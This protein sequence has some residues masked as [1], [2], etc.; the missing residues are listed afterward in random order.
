MKNSKNKTTLLAIFILGMAVLIG[1]CKPSIT[2][3]IKVLAPVS[4][5]ASRDEVIKVLK[6][7]YDK[8]YSDNK[9]CYAPIAPIHVSEEWKK[10]II[11][12]YN[13]LNKE[14]YAYVYPKDLINKMPD[15]AFVD[16]IGLLREGDY[17]GIAY[18]KIF[19]DSRTNYM[20]I[21]AGP[22]KKVH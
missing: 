7:A 21:L 16:G 18:F 14:G 4:L 3:V 1:G 17:E 15:I 12:L 20:G 10:S 22:V 13:S 2:D 9:E 19:Y 6:T 8:K 11:A 5:G